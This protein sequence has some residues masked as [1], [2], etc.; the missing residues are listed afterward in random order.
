MSN[1]GGDSTDYGD[2]LEL[3]AYYALEGKSEDWRGDLTAF[4]RSS[5]PISREIRD[6]FAKVIEG[7]DEDKPR[8]DLVNR[9]RQYDTQ[10]GYN[11]RKI[12]QKIGEWIEIKIAEGMTRAAAIELA[13]SNV[14]PAMSEKSCDAAL[15]YSRRAALW[16]DS[17]EPD[18][19]FIRVCGRERV[20]ELFHRMDAQGK[21]LDRGE[22]DYHLARFE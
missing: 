10:K 18:H 14:R 8:L 2:S 16:R 4:L 3:R 20:I 5:E 1:D 6:H 21:P 9:K 22:Q 19:P 15:D 17:L 11:R 12:W 13:S 7:F